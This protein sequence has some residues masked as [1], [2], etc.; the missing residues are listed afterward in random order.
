MLSILMVDDEPDLDLLIQQRFYKE[1]KSNQYKF[2]FARH[3]EEALRYLEQNPDVQL[4]ITD[5]N[6]PQMNGIQLLLNVKKKAPDK[7]V[8]VMSAYSDQ[9][10]IETAKKAGACDFL[11]KPLNFQTF[12]R[13]LKE[14]SAAAL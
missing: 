12:E 8:I 13:K 6:M 9:E 7:K 11:V 5:L 3:G 14:Y 2:L 10:N 1:I 4:V